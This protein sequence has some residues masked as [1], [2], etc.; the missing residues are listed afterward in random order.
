MGF[1]V[2]L[3]ESR[4]VLVASTKHHLENLSMAVYWKNCFPMTLLF[5][6]QAEGTNFT[7]TGIR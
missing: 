2:L 7:S 6:R 3:E 1:Q 5:I 4:L